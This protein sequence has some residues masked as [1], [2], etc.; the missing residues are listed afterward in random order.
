[1][2]CSPPAN[3]PSGVTLSCVCDNFGRSSLNP[4]TI[5]NSNW[6][7]STSD[8][9]GILPG[10]TNPGYLR[11]T[12]NTGNNAKAVTVPGIFP[13]SGNY[14]SVEFQQFAYSGT[15]PGADGIA[16]TL[17]DYSI[18]PVPG[19]FGGSLGYA[20]K[21][22]TSC[23]AGAAACPGFAGG[24]IGVALDEYGNYQNPTEG[25]IGGPGATSQS[26]AVR[27]SGSGNSGY[28]FIA[29]TIPLTPTIDNWSSTTPS[30]GNY[31]QVIVDARTPTSTSVVVN[32]DTGSG[33]SQLISIPNIF[34]AATAQG[35][36]QS[37]VP[38]NWQIS[39]T[40][41]TGGSNN[42][43]EIS[44]LKICAQS[45]QPPSGGT[46]GGFAM[47]D[48]AYGTP[49][50][51]AVQNYLTGHIY[52]KLVGVPFKLDVG[53]IQNNQ[54][55]T[56]YAA[57]SAKT[58]T[59]KLV[60]NTD[61]A[62][63]LDS[64]QANYC[65]STCT[66]KSAVSGGTQTLTFASGASDKGQKQAASF[67]LNSAYKNLIA[68]ASD[69]TTT[70]CSV[71]A[72]S[73]R[74]TAITS[75]TSSN[76]TYNSVTGTPVLKA[77]SDNF[78]LA[79][80]VAGVTGVANGYTGTLKI[81]K[82]ALQVTLPASGGT[83]GTVSPTTFPAAV[84]GTTTS[85]ATGTG[86]TYSEVGAFNLI[87]A[88]CSD[89]TGA[90]CSRGIFDG[91]NY[92][93]CGST[94]SA[95]CDSYKTSTWTAVDSISS[96]NDCVFGSYS[97]TMDANGKYG[98]NFGITA[99][100]AV[101]GRFTPARFIVTSGGTAGAVTAGC[102]STSPGF[103]YMGA[104]FAASFTL[105]ALNGAGNVTKN[106]QGTLAK[107]AP[108][109]ASDWISYGT[110]NSMGMWL[111]GTESLSGGTCNGYF[112]GSLSNSYATSF[113][114]CTGT[115]A[116]P[117]SITRA[118]GARVTALNPV[119]PTWASGVATFSTNLQLER[120]DAADGPYTLYV[121]I[122]PQDSDGVTLASSSFDLDADNNGTKERALL[123]DSTD[124]TH[125]PP[126]PLTV[127]DYYGRLL[128]NNTYGSELLNAPVSV[129][130]QYWDASK[131]RYVTNTSDGC[132]SLS[133]AN[134][135]FGNQKLGMTSSTVGVASGV[136]LASSG[137]NAG[138]GTL[139]ISKPSPRPTVSGSVDMSSGLSYLPGTGRLTFGLYKGAAPLIYLRELY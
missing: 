26:V 12:N 139:I 24:W 17:S 63:I 44:G 32:R 51:V 122:A 5:Y 41:S 36:T 47:I 120:A 38:D 31:Y 71:D 130:A 52:T 104:P 109:T 33:Y 101:L 138:T 11:L 23:P 106:Y 119:S 108:A 76:A 118:A 45:V 107:L 121:G 136:T 93:E 15:N 124:T 39:F 74:P 30:L 127:L 55:L 85:I 89:S 80:T 50:S 49:P 20:Q 79:A 53:V 129:T 67:I 125:N 62:C 7:T 18:A 61:G 14:I 40:G 27:G 78:S 112:S 117:A 103:S 96:K 88:S 91:V 98:C 69:G 64:S 58:V 22:G 86:F 123:R 34:N 10:I 60:D 65:N 99:N 25:R 16:V 46:A 131:G 94:S 48:E 84:S 6:T 35:F 42:I 59:V 19:A 81:D 115:A 37:P 43:H 92:L 70:A 73:V 95:A 116:A 126:N 13:A 4:S 77:G 66:S 2:S 90:T 3:A 83:A 111:V 82:N 72:F 114:S 29:G 57:S 1:M 8:S 75:V 133:S 102:T 68:I 134:L 9:T 113:G 21:T 128:I 132:T 56:T 28:N 105:T 135:S 100:T 87:V 137:P 97:N 54:I 110:A